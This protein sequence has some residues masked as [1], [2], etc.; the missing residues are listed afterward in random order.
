MRNKIF[1]AFFTVFFACS[2][3]TGTNHKEIPVLYGYV[4]ST[5]GK[6]IQGAFVE[7]SDLLQQTDAKGYY[8]FPILFEGQDTIKVT[9]DGYY[10][11]SQIIY[12]FKSN[13]RYDI[14]LTP[15]ETAIDSQKV[16][17]ALTTVTAYPS[18]LPPDGIS[19]S[20]IK[21]IPID[22]T[23]IKLG[24]GQKVLLNTTMG[25]LLDYVIYNSRDQSYTQQLRAATETGTA[26][27]TATVNGVLILNKAEIHFTTAKWV[28]YTMADGLATNIVNE[29]AIAPDGNIWF[30]CYP[31]G[32]TKFDGHTWTVYNKTNS[33]I[34]NN[35]VTSIDFDSEG[36][37]WFG[38]YGVYGGGVSKFDGSN[39]TT[40]RTTDGLADS[41][42]RY[43]MIDSKGNLWVGTHKGGVSKF[44]G[45]IW[46]TYNTTNGL[47][48]YD[49]NAITEDPDGN[50][51][52]G[53]NNGLSKFDGFHWT[54]YTT[55]DGL[56]E[57]YIRSLFI[58][59]DGTVWVG[60]RDAVNRFDG[61]DWT[62]YTPA[63]GLAYGYVKAI[64]KDDEG[65]IWFVTW[66]EPE[67]GGV[68]KFDGSSWTTYRTTDG[69]VSNQITS[70][71]IDS[72]GNIWFATWG[73]VSVLKKQ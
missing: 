72:D 9:K 12:L 36:N 38:V 47:A 43:V 68:S 42:V 30:G 2:S 66:G 52:I 63:D 22:Y 41:R 34:V 28:T 10:D 65:N 19:V 56:A 24:P 39:W 69:L 71:A 6:P 60:M 35:D 32:A 55:S 70:I 58:E 15:V 1:L 44:D 20:T 50:I 26:Y 8:Q 29:V 40:Y 61:S 73:G 64:N 25:T 17:P 7:V 59:K 13:Y 57:N 49:G 48:G 62:T 45:N 54:T 67:K 51:W 23:G 27:I 37:V 46:I 33:G 31:G 3:D 53:T 16:C 4:S 14:T 18:S 21:V 11:F 5:D